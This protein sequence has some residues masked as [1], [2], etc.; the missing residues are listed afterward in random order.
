MEIIGFEKLSLVDYDSR[1]ACTLF[2]GGCNFRCPFCHNGDLVLTPK[3]FD[4]QSIDEIFSYLAK[5]K[6]L[7]DGVVISGGEPTLQKDLVEFIAKIKSLGY[8]VKLDTNGTNPS[9]VRYLANEKLIDFVAMDVK[10]SKEGYA[11]AIGLKGFPSSV[12]ETVDFLKTNV[13]DY[14][15]RMTLVSELITKF[16]IENTAKWLEGSK[17]VYLQKFVERDGCIKKGL[18]EVPKSLACEYAEI[19]ENHGI[20]AILRN[21]D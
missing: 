20:K 14:E 8:A 2:T 4:L 21:Y 9:M 18:T 3:A 6:G 1:A 15:F 13:V 7:L 17:I 5:R 12:A 11:K 16:D 10:S 19:F